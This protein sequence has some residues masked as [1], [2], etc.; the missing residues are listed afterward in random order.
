MT[1]KELED[2]AL[3]LAPKARARLTAKLLKSL[4]GLS[5]PEID[6][7]WA[8]E[9]K[10]RDDAMNQNPDDARPAKTVL[11]EARSRLE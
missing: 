5:Q 11:E 6:Q 10:R 3:K 7:A 1:T 9:A 2:E 4:E 8:G